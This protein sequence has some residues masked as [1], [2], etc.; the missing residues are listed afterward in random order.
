MPYLLFCT[1]D[2][3]SLV[4]LC[5]I[6]VEKQEDIAAFKDYTDTGDATSTASPAKTDEKAKHDASS[7]TNPSAA[8][9]T[10][11]EASREKKA[12]STSGSSKGS[13]VIASPLA[14]KLAEESGIQLHVSTTE[15]THRRLYFICASVD[16]RNR[17]RWSHPCRRCREIRQE[18][19]CPNGEGGTIDVKPT[20]HEA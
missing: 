7:E 1:T 13:R 4:Q 20:S 11:K 18:G 17:S 19:G 5:A 16:S 14:R 3:L 15:L 2:S 12:A 8:S 9:V 10:K 6:I